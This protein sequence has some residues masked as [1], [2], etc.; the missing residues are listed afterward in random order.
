[1]DSLITLF[2]SLVYKTNINR[3]LNEK[4]KKFI[5]EQS[6]QAQ[7]TLSNSMSI[8]NK[9]LDNV[10]FE[11]IKSFVDNKIDFFLQQIV[12]P[13]HNLKCYVTESWLNFNKKGDSHHKH[14]HAN[15]FLS[16]VFYINVDGQD[17]ITFLSPLKDLITIEKK[18][19]N[20]LNANYATIKIKQGDL[21]IFYSHLDH[22]VDINQK[23][24]TRISLSFNTFL[25][26]TIS[27]EFTSALK[28]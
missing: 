20:E 3:S 18:E 12:Q 14:F 6:T 15:S 22:K 28:I 24:E 10:N 21:V 16:G 4:E 1:M 26:G 7:P 13:K 2:P 17:S 8:D 27:N 9:I 5:K 25:K 11:N 23:N 19:E